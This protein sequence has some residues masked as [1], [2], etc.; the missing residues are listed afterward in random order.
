MPTI[1]EI[2]TAEADV[3]EN[4]TEA[5]KAMY[6]GLGHSALA[7]RTVYES[8]KTLYERALLDI[9]NSGIIIEGLSE[10]SQLKYVSYDPSSEGY[11]DIP[12]DAIDRRRFHQHFEPVNFS[13]A[14]PG[15][16]PEQDPESRE[17]QP[18]IFFR[19]RNSGYTGTL[20]DIEWRRY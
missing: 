1:G 12:L 15:I 11:V 8:A 6:I 14:V 18:R 4:N 13:L 7:D 19:R 5:L 10:D 9:I 20:D 16:T 2:A 17:V 3:F